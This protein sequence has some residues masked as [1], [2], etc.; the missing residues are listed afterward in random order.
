MEEDNS[1]YDD[2]IEED[3]GVDDDMEENEDEADE[4]EEEAV[5]EAV[6]GSVE[7]EKGTEYQAL[8]LNQNDDEVVNHGED[9][10]DLNKN[11]GGKEGEESSK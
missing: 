10:D 3:V 6:K 8:E 5:P 9:D 2:E 11:D 4:D 7:H 1:D